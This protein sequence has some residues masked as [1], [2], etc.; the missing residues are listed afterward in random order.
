MEYLRRLQQLGCAF[1]DVSSGGLSPKQQIAVGPERIKAATGMPTIAVGLIA[2]PEQ[3]EQILTANRADCIAL[4]RGMLYHPRWLW[5]AAARL[6]TQVEALPQ[7]WRAA[8]LGSFIMG[9]YG[10]GIGRVVWC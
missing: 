4:A 10:S 8:A 1:V 9:R 2:E 5:H 7:F 6:G 3:A